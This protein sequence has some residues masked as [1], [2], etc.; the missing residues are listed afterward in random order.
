M[1]ALLRDRLINNIKIEEEV[2]L[3]FD[4]VLQFRWNLT[5]GVLLRMLYTVENQLHW[6][7]FRKKLKWHVLQMLKTLLQTLLKQY[8]KFSGTMI[9]MS[10]N[11][12]AFA[13]LRFGQCKQELHYVPFRH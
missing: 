13:N 5:Y 12:C 6:Q 3:S 11:A 4:R 9:L 10:T 8:T 7:H 2:R 1:L